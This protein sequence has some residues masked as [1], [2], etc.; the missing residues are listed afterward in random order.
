M[1]TLYTYF[2]EK[3][4]IRF[5]IFTLTFPVK[6]LG[7]P[8]TQIQTQ[9]MSVQILK[10]GVVFCITCSLYLKHSTAWVFMRNL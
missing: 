2:P 10:T 7:I 3:I 8:L 1:F 4:P 5:K 9:R 6:T